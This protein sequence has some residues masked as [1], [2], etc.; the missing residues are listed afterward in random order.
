[1]LDTRALNT[2]SVTAACRRHTYQQLRDAGWSVA[3]IAAH[4]DTSTKAVYKVLNR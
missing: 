4:T 3:D 2:R 1:M